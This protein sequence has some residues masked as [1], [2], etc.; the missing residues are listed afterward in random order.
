MRPILLALSTVLALSGCGG[1]FTTVYG[2]G[3]QGLQN[4]ASDTLGQ[5]SFYRATDDGDH[6]TDTWKYCGA[7]GLPDTYL[8][9]HYPKNAPSLESLAVE[10][11]DRESSSTAQPIIHEQTFVTVDGESVE[12]LHLTTQDTN[13][14]RVESVRGLKTADGHL[15][16]CVV[17]M[18]HPFGDGGEVAGEFSG[19]DEALGLCPS[20]LRTLLRAVRAN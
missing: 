19:R 1:A 14:D 9:V 5:C 13:I 17:D 7:L 10:F 11:A 4:D 8:H 12:S 15:F 6:T 18:R 16:L 3:M 20:A 2:D